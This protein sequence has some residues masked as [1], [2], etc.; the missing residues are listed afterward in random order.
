[1]KTNCIFVV[2]AIFALSNNLFG[3][4]IFENGII[5]V[6]PNRDNPYSNGQTFDS[7]IT[8]SGIGR[9]SGLDADDANNRYNAREWTS[10]SFDLNDY[11]EFKITP[12]PGYKIDFVKFAY[13]AQV[14]EKGPISFALR[15]SADG[16]S[17]NVATPSISYSV[18]E[19]T[20]VPIDLSGSSL[21]NC[22]S[23]II[24]RFYG[25]GGSDTNGTFS[26]NE[27]AFS[28]VVSC[29]TK[30]PDI[31]DVVQPNCV[32]AGSIELKNLPADFKWDLYQ[33]DILILSQGV[34]S[35]TTVYGLTDGNY[36]YKVDDGRCKSAISRTVVIKG[37][38]TNTW[39]NGRWSPEAPPTT[40][41][42]KI[43]FADNYSLNA[44]V[45]GC[46]CVVSA[47]KNVI[48]KDGRTLK[49]EN[50]IYVQGTGTLTFENNAS[51]VQINDQA[52][53]TGNIVYKRKT[54]PIDKFDYTY[55]SSPVKDQTLI[56][57]SPNTL[58]DKFY[59]FNSAIND[60][61][62]ENPSNVM[63]V[64]KGYIIRGPQEYTTQTAS[65][66]YEASFIGI[67]NSGIITAPIGINGSFNLIGNPYPSALD[68]NSFL[69]YN[70]DLLDGT[71]Y[72]W[73]HNTDIAVNNPNPGSGTYAYTSDD[74]ASYNLT[75]GVG[76]KAHSSSNSGAVN[77][78]APSGKIASGQSFFTKSIAAG[79]V[80]FNNS[81]RVGVGANTGDNSQFFKLKTVEKTNSPP[82][83]TR[84]WL[85]LSNSQG[86]F[87]QTLI[88]YIAGGTDEY[89]RM[90]DGE[91]ANGNNFVDFYSLCRDKKLVI[92]G[93][94]LPF[95]RSDSIP[96]GYSANFSGSLIID[97]DQVD[98]ALENENI[99]IEDKELNVIHNLALT[100][101][102]FVTESGTFNTRFV[103][104]YIDNTKI[105]DFETTLI[106]QVLVSNKN[107]QLSIT[108]FVAPIDKVII[109]D[110]EARR[111]Y[112]KTNVESHEIKMI[113]LVSNKQ[114]L[115]VKVVLKDGKSVVKKIIY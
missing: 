67:P 89:D 49:I 105:S 107:K 112:Q 69:R 16:F 17:S 6:N 95:N 113:N 65:S 18:G 25:W 31:G 19:Q 57:V 3:Q 43:V 33:N 62:Q 35:S 26:I 36:N 10:V 98:G 84:V 115:F 42:N 76:T 109:F 14:S 23:E 94:A 5:G 60:W 39:S 55:W 61:Q 48:I 99:F 103:L 70:K 85:N 110:T 45:N 106:N 73:T 91:S 40:L 41:T 108:S 100:P 7:N 88:G 83:K 34:G 38:I 97:I 80:T 32:A 1:M 72:F 22:I 56:A 46:S 28:G 53:N 12:N 81:M 102:E 4:V 13:K 54:T 15:S 24:F 51:L 63:E 79:N 47:D 11:F 58:Q 87:K 104:R 9:G 71:I 30:V 44:A 20:P 111:V 52:V 64:G 50:G 78:N 27:F 90:F 37:P 2:V 77:S 74:Y 66:T 75:G 82:E 29:A 92:Q 86:V 114:I 96:L 68:A 93:K 59:S 21:Q 8:V 101:Y